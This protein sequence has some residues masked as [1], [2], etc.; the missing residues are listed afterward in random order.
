MNAR[1]LLNSDL[2]N[3]IETDDFDRFKH[4]LEVGANPN[5]LLS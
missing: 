1:Q 2:M 3:S 5:S 4:L